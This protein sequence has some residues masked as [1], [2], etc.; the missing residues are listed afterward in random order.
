M[1]QQ[2]THHFYGDALCFVG[3]EGVEPSRL[4]THDPKSSHPIVR[5]Y[6]TRIHGI[7]L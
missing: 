7:G 3:M 2:K 4:A 6:Y 5:R 1:T